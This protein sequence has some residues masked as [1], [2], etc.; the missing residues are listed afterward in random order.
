MQTLI[1][2]CGPNGEKIPITSLEQLHGIRSRIENVRPFTPV[3]IVTADAS[4]TGRYLYQANKKIQ[5]D[6]SDVKLHW[7]HVDKM[8]T[9]LEL[10]QVERKL[11]PFG[12]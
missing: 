9:L 3:N 2:T 8:M 6:V 10:D 12:K 11:P 1:A 7:N 4:G 5:I